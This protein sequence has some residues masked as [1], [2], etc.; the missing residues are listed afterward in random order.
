MGTAYSHTSTMNQLHN[1]RVPT[2]ISSP[3]VLLPAPS[4]VTFL[5]CP[6]RR[7]SYVDSELPGSSITSFGASVAASNALQSTYATEPSDPDIPLP[8]MHSSFKGDSS[9]LTMAFPK[10]SEQISWNQEPLQGVF[11]YPT[12]LDFSDQQNPTTVGQQIQDSITVNPSTHLAKQNEWFPSGSSVQFLGS[13]GSVLEAVDAITATPQN[14]CYCHTQSSMPDPFNCDAY[15]ADNLPSSNTTP[16]KSRIRWTP[17]LHER[18][19][20][21]IN[22]LGGSEKATPKA[23]QKV[24]KVEGLTIYHVKS[25]L[26]KYRAVQHRSQ[27]SDGACAKRSSQTDEVSLLQ[28]KGTGSIEGLRTQIGLQKQ[29][30]EQ[31]EIQRKLQLQVEE[32]SKYLEMIIA[33]QSES[34]KKLGALPGFRDQ[35]QPVLGDSKACEERTVCT[36]SAELL[37]K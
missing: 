6:E 26:Q 12:N 8:S 3:T 20:D 18:F 33:K 31:L 36:N 37:G 17:E 35:S 24:M 1:T 11:D 30:H 32:H 2:C 29:L 23:L 5:S 9:S 10:V 13:A 22:K 19:V 25:H 16:T 7:P 15:C 27:S 14:Y 21:A 28:L 34:L 4:E